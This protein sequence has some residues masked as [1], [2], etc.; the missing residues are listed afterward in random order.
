[1]MIRKVTSVA[2]YNTI[3]RDIRKPVLLHMEQ[4]YLS[5]PEQS[6]LDGKVRH[7]GSDSDEQLLWRPTFW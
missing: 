5:S 3:E 6:S 4:K 7:R 2:S 1:M